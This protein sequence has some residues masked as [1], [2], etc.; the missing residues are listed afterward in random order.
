MELEPEGDS[1]DPSIPPSIPSD[2]NAL[3]NSCGE[4]TYLYDDP[5]DD[6]DGEGE[7][8]TPS[9]VTLHRSRA[10]DLL[11]SPADKHNGKDE[12]IIAGCMTGD[13]A[14]Q[15]VLLQMGLSLV[16]V[17][18]RRIER[19]KSWVLRCHACFKYA[20][21]DLSFPSN[22]WTDIDLGYVKMHPR[23]SVPR[24]ETQ[25]YSAHP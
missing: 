21:H 15:N 17:E 5:S 18:G 23:N 8:I 16:G 22:I 6:D 2:P 19:V 12:V 10:L 11:P 20:E 13:F 14:M 25:P 7:W 3:S 1:L 4:P 24:A 9:N